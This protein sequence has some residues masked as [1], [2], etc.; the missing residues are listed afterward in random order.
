M[1]IEVYN[2][3]FVGNLQDCQSASDFAI[4]HACKNP[5]HKSGVGYRGNLSSSHP[6][7]LIKETSD[8][9]YLNLVDMNRIVPE[10]TDEPIE[11]A[12]NF[13]QSNLKEGKKVLIHCNLGQSRSCSIAIIYL[14]RYNII[15]NE[16]YDLALNDFRKLYPIV[17]IGF[18]FKNYLI[19]NWNGLMGVQN[20]A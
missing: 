12:I 14:A 3:L 11:K 2:D 15:S 18:G 7:Y 8:N 10:Y 20:E 1:A 9:L 6:N 5:C 16:S 17:D 19:Q 13:I 4:I